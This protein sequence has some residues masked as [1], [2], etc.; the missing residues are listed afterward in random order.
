MC[1]IAGY[2]KYRKCNVSIEALTNR[3]NNEGTY[4]YL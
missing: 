4:S 3:L 2:Y 1:G